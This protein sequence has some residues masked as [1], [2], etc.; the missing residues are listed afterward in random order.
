MTRQ[1]VIPFCV[2]FGSS[3]RDLSQSGCE[4]KSKAITRKK[5]QIEQTK[6]YDFYF[7]SQAEEY[8]FYCVPDV[9]HVHSDTQ[10]RTVI[11]V[12]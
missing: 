5:S 12:I 4:M 3:S 9:K 11:I 2:M 8:Q 10:N 1:G 6:K 7:D